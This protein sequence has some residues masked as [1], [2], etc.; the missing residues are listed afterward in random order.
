MESNLYRHLAGGQIGP[1]LRAAPR[2][3]RQWSALR[4]QGEVFSPGRDGTVL[5]VRAAD[6]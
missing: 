6:G 5:V 4:P 2:V 1:Y 3:F